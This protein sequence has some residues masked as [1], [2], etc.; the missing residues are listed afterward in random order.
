MGG[1][2]TDNRNEA[3]KPGG[4]KA[5]VWEAK[6]LNGARGVCSIGCVKPGLL[7]AQAGGSTCCVKP[8]GRAKKSE[9]FG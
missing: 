1:M 6:A 3:E 8:K 5:Q 7:E 9:R 2:G 4:A